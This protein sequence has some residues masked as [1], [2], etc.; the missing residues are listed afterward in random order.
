MSDDK[1][2]VPE[3]GEAGRGDDEIHYHDVDET[4]VGE[5][6]RAQKPQADEAPRP[7]SHE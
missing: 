5:A 4:N 2:A 1:K 3:P 7:E 6:E